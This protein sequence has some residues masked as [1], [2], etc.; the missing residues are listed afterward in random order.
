[1]AADDAT[2]TPPSLLE[3]AWFDVLVRLPEE[4]VN[5]MVTIYRVR[6]FKGEDP[7][8]KLLQR[9]LAGPQPLTVDTQLTMMWNEAKLFE[10]AVYFPAGDRLV[11]V[12]ARTLPLATAH[13]LATA[14]CHSVR[15][16]LPG[17]LK[18]L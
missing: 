3:Q 9:M 14:H 15:L 12:L 2:A 1:M 6:V 8:R 10:W 13:S 17:P 4:K 18:P 7:V 16:P 11:S 5:A